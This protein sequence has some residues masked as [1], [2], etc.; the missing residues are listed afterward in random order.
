MARG[1]LCCRKTTSPITESQLAIYVAVVLI[2]SS[3]ADT[4]GSSHSNTTSPALT[5]SPVTPVGFDDLSIKVAGANSLALSIQYDKIPQSHPLKQK[6]FGLVVR[7]WPVLLFFIVF[8]FPFTSLAHLLRAITTSPTT[9]CSLDDATMYQA[10]HTLRRCFTF[11]WTPTVTR[12]LSRLIVL[13]AFGVLIISLPSRNFNILKFHSR[14]FCPIT[15]I[16]QTN[17]PCVI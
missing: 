17:L 8:F 13:V 4:L 11:A 2:T 9:S 6:M 7:C 16:I 1:N 12:H 14:E 3:T 5:L 15:A 10:D